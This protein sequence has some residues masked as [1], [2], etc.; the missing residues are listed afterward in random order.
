MLKQFHEGMAAQNV[1]NSAGTLT[2]INGVKQGPGTHPVSMTVTVR[3]LPERMT[4]VSISIAALVAV[5]SPWKD[6]K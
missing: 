6:L 5:H 3:L 1:D 4:V 2:V